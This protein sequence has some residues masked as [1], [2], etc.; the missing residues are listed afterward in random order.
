MVI[1]DSERGSRSEGS[2]CVACALPLFEGAVLT[3]YWFRRLAGPILHSFYGHVHS[4]WRF[5]SRAFHLLAIHSKIILSIHRQ[6]FFQYN[7]PAHRC[8]DFDTIGCREWKILLRLKI[9]SPLDELAGYVQK[10]R[11]CKRVTVT[12]YSCTWVRDSWA[13]SCPEIS[14]L[15]RWFSGKYIRQVQ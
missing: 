7:Q 2:P 5:P 6:S 15:Y 14:K 1:S 9:R 8:F 11:V 12:R 3:K 13:G 4:L 10:T